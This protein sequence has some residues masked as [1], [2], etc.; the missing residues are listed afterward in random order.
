MIKNFT[1]LL[2]VAFFA[3]F[4]YSQEGTRIEKTKEIS[5]YGLTKVQAIQNALIEATKQQNGASIQSV[6]SVFKTY[7][8]Q[9][10]S[11]NDIN[12]YQSLMQ[13]GIIQKIRVATNGYIDKYDII[14]IIEHPSDFEAKIKVTTVQYKTP[15]HSVHKRRKIVIVPSYTNDIMYKVLDNYKSAKD[16]SLSLNQELTNTLTKTRKF[17]IL[18]RQNKHAYNLEKNII[19]SPDAH[20]DELLKLGNTVGADYLIVSDITNFKIIKKKT[21]I[22]GLNL[23]EVKAIVTIKY[24][25]ITMATRQIKWSNTSTFEF[26]PSGKT[27]NQIFLN[28]LKKISEDLTYEII[29]NIY[30]IKIVDISANG[31]VILNQSL[32]LNSTYEIYSLGNKLFDSYTKEFLGYDE[33]HIGTIKIVRSLPKISYGKIIQGDA[34]KGAICR[35][36]KKKIKNYTN[37]KSHTDLKQNM[38]KY[39]VIKKLSISS[40]IDKYKYKYIK[41]ANIEQKI[42]TIVNLSKKYKVL[43]RDSEQVK[44]LMEERQIAQN[45]ISDNIDEDTMRLSLTDYQLLPKITKFKLSRSSRK[46]PNIDIYE[47]R[48]FA[49]IELSIALINR[50]GEIEF[51]ST[52]SQTYTSTWTS[53]YKAKGH[54][55]YKTINKISKKV[56]ANVLYDLLNEKAQMLS[57]KFITV[58]E[59]GKHTIYLDLADNQNIQEGDIFPVY[60]EPVVKTIKRTGK[61]RLS[62]GEKIATVKIDAI[63][64]DGAEAVVIKGKIRNIK[65]G[66]ILRLHKRKGK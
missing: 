38:K 19:L 23:S 1:K 4:L 6:K 16:I 24:R 2:L 14:K 41:D 28:V 56:V 46:I 35:K 29:E 59:V 30:P 26:K 33:I 22:S 25:I 20:K 48:D 21:N 43:T 51:E 31:N 27:N 49:T 10:S 37:K 3:T 47:N 42:K 58:V 44:A 39:I 17:S 36:S 52:K 7:A 15:G 8:Q 12:S 63:F 57:K 54:P 32:K 66:Y 61:T 5:G 13:D 53:S 9:S 60:R 11:Q 64:D 34:Q 45:D 65:E 55:S 18:D 40:N 62:Y 50:K